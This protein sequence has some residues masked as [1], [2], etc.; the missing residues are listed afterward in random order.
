MSISTTTFTLRLR[1]SLGSTQMNSQSKA[2]KKNLQP[3]SPTPVCKK[4]WLLHHLNRSY[5]KPV[6]IS[7]I[8][9]YYSAGVSL[10]RILFQGIRSIITQHNWHPFKFRS[11]SA[12]SLSSHWGWCSSR[13]IFWPINNQKYV[14]F[15]HSYLKKKKTALFIWWLPS[16]APVLCGF[17]NSILEWHF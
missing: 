1:T 5:H 6:G 14:Y 16:L 7:M 17:F 15:K 9:G 11:N 3:L 12:I 4:A 13:A 2:S 8:W 10:G